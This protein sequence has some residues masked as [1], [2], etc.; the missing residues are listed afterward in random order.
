MQYKKNK[1]LSSKLNNRLEIWGNTKVETDLGISIE[2][3]LVK[4]IWGNIIPTSG[5][6][7]T[8]EADNVS[9]DVKVKIKIRK[10]EISSANWVVF[11]GNRYDISYILPD[12]KSNKYLELYAV[13]NI[14]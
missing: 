14:E 8:G 7:S 11:G 13:L 1:S 10:T 4:K 3:T 12:L 6:L 9:N 2:E 5:A